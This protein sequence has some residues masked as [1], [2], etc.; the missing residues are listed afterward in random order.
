VI[1]SPHRSP[2]IE[3]VQMRLNRLNRSEATVRCL[4]MREAAM[5]D[6]S[7]CRRSQEGHLR[8]DAMHSISET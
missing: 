3:R 1:E 6:R 8:Y 7:V 2:S 5:I 4:S